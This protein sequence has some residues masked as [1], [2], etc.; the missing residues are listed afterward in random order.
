MYIFQK[1][2]APRKICVSFLVAGEDT[3]GTLLTILEPDVSIL[4]F[5]SY[6]LNFLNTS[7]DLAIVYGKIIQIDFY[8]FLFQKDFYLKNF[9]LCVVPHNYILNVLQVFW[10]LSLFQ[11][12]LISPMQIVSLDFHP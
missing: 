9:L 10:T 4:Q 6:K 12:S 11:S 3:A 1:P 7:L 8:Y 5:Y 2:T